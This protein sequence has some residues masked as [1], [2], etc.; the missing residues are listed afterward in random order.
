MIENASDIIS[1]NHKE[2]EKIKKNVMVLV[3]TS[4]VCFTGSVCSFTGL[5]AFNCEPLFGTGV[6]CLTLCAASTLV[7]G[8]NIKK[9]DEILEENRKLFI[10][11]EKTL[12]KSR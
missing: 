11:S 12:K 9:H 4:Y 6:A 1:K 2:C 3:P 10:N 7:L 8:K 5:F